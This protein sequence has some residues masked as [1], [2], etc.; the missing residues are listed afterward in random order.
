M[1]GAK[2][3]AP[4]WA[5][6][7][8]CIARPP[9]PLP[10]HRARS[11]PLH[12]LRGPPSPAARV[13]ILGATAR[14]C[15]GSARRR[16]RGGPPSGREVDR[17]QQQAR[18]GDLAEEA[19]PRR[20]RLLR[21]PIEDRRPLRLAALQ[22]VVEEVAGDDRA[23]A[24]GADVDA[25]MAGRMARRRSQP[26]RVVEREIVV[27]E[28]RLA[29]LDDGLAVEAPDIARRVVAAPRRLLPGGVFA[30]VE[31]VFGP[32]E[33]RHPAPVAQDRVPAAVIDVE[34][35]AEHVVDVLEPEAGGAKA[36]EPGRLREVHRRGIAL[37][38]AGAGVDEDRVP[39]RAHDEGLVGDHHL[40]GGLIEHPRL[41][42]GDVPLAE[43]RVVVREHVLRPAPRPVA[44]DDAR[45][46]HVS[47][48]QA[49]H[50]PP[51]PVLPVSSHKA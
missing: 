44:L 48:R 19:P 49:A 42:L 17:Q 28:E 47:D 23:L 45:D 46:R 22:G 33:G 20:D 34:M 12:R 29:G 21:V 36:L 24:A 51:P 43:L 15:S 27:D 40:A 26:H 8:D 10:L 6:R 16:P 25:A 1:E 32:R 50:A 39:G 37:V 2:R 38:L 18:A 31:D 7:R 41:K 5:R 4:W 9:P 3:R 14:S 11:C 30:L 35:R 13:R